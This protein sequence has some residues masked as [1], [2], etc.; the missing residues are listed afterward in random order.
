[1]PSRVC[2][3]V[4]MR[5]LSGIDVSFLNMETASTFGHVASL[6][7]YDPTGVPGGAG[8]DVTKR[9]IL[10]RID[11]LA[12]FRRRLVEVPLGLDLPYWIEDPDFDIDFHVRPTP[13]RRPAIPNSSVR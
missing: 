10:E 2:T 6:N 12:P 13:C 9:M 1:M 4:N 7:I 11:Q 5:Q 8:L 3:L